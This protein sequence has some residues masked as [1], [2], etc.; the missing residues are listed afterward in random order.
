MENR[1]YYGGGIYFE[2]IGEPSIEDRNSH[3]VGS[4]RVP[5]RPASHWDWDGEEWVEGI[6]E[7][8]VYKPTD[9]SP[10]RFEYLLAYTGLDDVWVA[11]EAEL[12]TIDR[13]KFAQI[14]AQRKALSFPQ[15][16]TLALVAM[17]ATTAQ[18]VAP[19]AD[20][21]EDAIKAAWVIAEEVVL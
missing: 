3:P 21:S 13:A 11:L 10:R 5:L 14:K 17:F 6:N 9:L 8:M 1:G 16:K 15:E 7:A 2:T 12:K 20:L 4:V 19:D 18:A